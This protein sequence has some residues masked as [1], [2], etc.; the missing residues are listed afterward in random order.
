MQSMA[1]VGLPEMS[2]VT[3]IIALLPV[4]VCLVLMMQFQMSGGRAGM[5]AWLVSLAVAS[6]SFGGGIDVLASGTV[7]GLWTTLFVLYIVWSSMFLYNVVECTGSFKV[8][9][10]MFTKLTNGNR[11]LQLLILGWVFP[12]FIQGV[13]GFGVPVA[14]AAPLLLGL[15]FNP[16]LAVVTPLLGHSWGVTFGSLGSSYS[17]LLQLSPVDPARMAWIASLFIAFGGWIVGFCICHAYGGFKGIKEGTPAVVLLMGIMT[18][19]L[20]VMCRFVSA[21]VATFVAGALGLVLGSILLPKMP[22]YR[23]DP[24]AE[25]APEDP[26]GSKFSF[27]TAFSA[28]VILIAVVFCVYLIAPLKAMLEAPAFQLGLAFPE[29]VTSFGYTNAATEKYSALKIFTTPGTLIV[30]SSILAILFYKA[31]GVFPA[32]GVAKSLSNTAKQSI[33]ATTT[34]MTMTMMAVMMTEA[35]M[36]TYIAYGIAMSTGKLFAIFS[37]FIALI[38]GFVTSSGTSS[39]ILFTGLQYGVADILGISPYVVLA[40]QTTASSLSNSFSPGNVALG[41]GVTGLSGREGE[42]LKLTGVYC[43]IQCL[44][45]GILGWVAIYIMNVQ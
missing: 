13:C 5:I 34:I 2:I 20:V 22:M 19:G 12:S 17:V 32:G 1:E 21:Y 3:W 35:G 18:V 7:K 24:N 29:T 39:N 9:A 23:P 44:L 38:G 41:T 25:P 30:I 40:M 45:V 14:V 15:G 33:G 37:P 31:K 27:M 11:M 26:D 10:A 6:F 4:I 42:C 16:I 28:Y 36:T 43:T 8:I